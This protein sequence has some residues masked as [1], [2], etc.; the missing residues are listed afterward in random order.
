M[1][2][3]SLASWLTLLTR[4]GFAVV[5]LA[6]L[7]NAVMAYTVVFRDGHKVE[8]P[9]VFMLTAATL[10]YEAAPGINR[11]VQL[12]LID[13][14]ATERANSETPGGFLKHAE[15]KDA[16]PKAHR[17]QRT[18]TN[19]DLEASRQRRLASEQ[20]YEKRRAELGLPSIEETRR[21]EAKEEEATI[22]LA[23]RRATAVAN[24]EAYWR[25]RARAL[26]NE[27]VTVDAE[28][29]YVRAR[30]GPDRQLPWITQGFI[31]TAVPFG[32][33]G[34]RSNMTQ[35]GAGRMGTQGASGP[36]STGLTN[37]GAA[38]IRPQRPAGFVGF[39]RGGFI[40]SFPIVPYAYYGNSSDLS[41]RLDD[42]LQR[43]AG[44]EAL[45]RELER[46]ARLAKVP[47]IWLA[48]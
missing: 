3:N 13:I 25:S 28:I 26:R 19:L 34:G 5:L 48:P 8:V 30:L 46:D 27:I 20:A 9:P 40:P 43:R 39:S 11:T 41:F 6:A 15:R 17:A 29:N 38:A 18:L 12:V 35:R 44:L 36:G 37:L 21:R 22:D 47:Q 1:R 45:W 10:T 14:P 2:K 4:S 16:S 24:D 42:L 33:F 7:A 23:R 31:T 32:P